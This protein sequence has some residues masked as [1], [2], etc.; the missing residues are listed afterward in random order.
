MLVARSRKG[1][2]NR[3]AEPPAGVV[4]QTFLDP[5]SGRLFPETTFLT[6]RLTGLSSGRIC[7]TRQT[8]FNMD[9]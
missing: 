4:R 1:A 6:M 2:T 9:R 7:A 8:T 5:F 3:V